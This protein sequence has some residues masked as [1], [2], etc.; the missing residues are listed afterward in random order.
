M[1]VGEP[2][3]RHLRT[4]EPRPA[5]WRK[6]WS[7]LRAAG[8]WAEVIETKPDEP[9]SVVAKRAV[10]EGFSMVIAGGGET[11]RLVRRPKPWWARIA[12]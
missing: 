6:I 4:E 7:E 5:R 12:L 9:P 3:V 11:A 1:L 10:E 8:I 2:G